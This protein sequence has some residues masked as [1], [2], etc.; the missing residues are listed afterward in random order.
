MPDAH[1]SYTRT[2]VLVLCS[3]MNDH[4][5]RRIEIARS[6]RATTVE[7]LHVAA[8]QR[9]ARSIRDEW[10]ARSLPVPLT[11]LG[12]AGR[13]VT[14]TLVDYV[15][16]IASPDDLVIAVLPE[17][18]GWWNSILKGRIVRG[19]TQRLLANPDVVVA[20]TS[21]RMVGGADDR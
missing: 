12:P 11:I 21:T 1:G 9:D 17:A 6:L 20:T 13:N 7:M 18:R 5:V 8:D 4:V 3:A 10:R 14:Q 15:G 16:E 2:H 19:L